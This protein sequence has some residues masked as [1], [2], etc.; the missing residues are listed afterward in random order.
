MPLGPLWIIPGYTCHGTQ[1]GEL[2]YIIK[3]GTSVAVSVS[4]L[5]GF[6]ANMGALH[7]AYIYGAPLDLNMPSHR[8]M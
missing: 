5:S 7:Y 4:G 1:I 2:F 8:C 3:L 6:I